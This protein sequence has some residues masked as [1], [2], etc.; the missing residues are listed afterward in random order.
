LTSSRPAAFSVA[1]LWLSSEMLLPDGIG[2]LLPCGIPRAH[3]R[4]A[5]SSFLQ[6]TFTS[7]APAANTI[8]GDCPPSACGKPRAFAFEILLAGAGVSAATRGRRRTTSR[9]SSLQRLMLDGMWPASGQSASAEFVRNAG[10]RGSFF[11]RHTPRRSDP[12]T[13]SRQHSG[14]RVTA[15][16]VCRPSTVRNRCTSIRPTPNTL[17]GLLSPIFGQPRLTR[18]S[19]PRSAFLVS[20]CARSWRTFR[21]LEVPS[22]E[23]APDEHP[24]GSPPRL[25]TSVGRRMGVSHVFV[26][27]RRLRLDP[28]ACRSSRQLQGRMRF[29]DFCRKCFNEHD[30]GPL[31]HPSRTEHVRLG[32]LQG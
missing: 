12:L 13:L 4:D 22:I 32:R 27:V 30:Q 23:E 19:T 1:W 18:V 16:S 24:R 29:C 2:H 15:P 8:F 21:E 28:S 5:S 3:R 20:C 31:E 25:P 17:P 10:E 9:S 11:G 7:R 14:E 26:D 6:L